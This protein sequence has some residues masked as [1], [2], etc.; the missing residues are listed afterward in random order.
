MKKEIIEW[1]K[2]IIF[3]VVFVGIINIFFVPTMVYSIS[4]NPTL[5]EKDLLI[6]RR[7]HDVARGDIVSFKSNLKITDSDIDKLN[8]IQRLYV[9]TNSRKNLIKRVIAIP[10]DSLKI[11]NGEVYVNGILQQEDYLGSETNGELE[12]DKLGENEYFMMGDNRSHSLDSRYPS[13]GTI[14]GDDI[15]GK[16]IF[17]ILPFSRIGMVK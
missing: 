13:V 5:V 16:V 3:A 7:T 14:S 1:I 8:F 17:R 11:S 6:L 9:N 4:M 15:I 10:G 2:S 12:I